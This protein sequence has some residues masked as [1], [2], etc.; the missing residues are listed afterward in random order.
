VVEAMLAAGGLLAVSPVLALT[1][2]AIALTSG[3]PIFFRQ[4]R[5]GRNGRPFTLVKF[6]TMRASRGGPQVTAGDDPRVT[7]L[8]KLL[9]R[10][11]LDELPELWNVLVGDM[12]FVGPRPEVPRYV[13]TD[14]ALWKEVL[15]V[16]PGLTDP[17]T[18][19]LRDEESL[20]ARVEGD[21]EAF[22]VEV[23][24]PRKLEGYLEYLHRRSWKTD[25]VVI[26]DTL[27]ALFGR[28]STA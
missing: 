17:A 20:M 1:A 16:R 5:M 7:R 19:R 12:S 4:A 10:T 6:R 15:T 21:R 27:R 11:K 18:L 26:W 13:D 23:L 2:A 28:R 8:G 25:L 24:Q 22:Y 3:F 9:R 14:S